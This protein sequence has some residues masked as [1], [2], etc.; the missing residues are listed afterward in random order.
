[1]L[2]APSPRMERALINRGLR[3]AIFVHGTYNFLLFSV[4]VL[5]NLALVCLIP[6]LI[7]AFLILRARIRIAL[8]EDRR[9]AQFEQ[10]V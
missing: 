5:G 2:I 8:E 3:I 1:M 9:R 6:L 7:G 4:P 10:A